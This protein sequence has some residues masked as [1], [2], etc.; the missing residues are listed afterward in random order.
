MARHGFEENHL[1]VHVFA[2]TA[3]FGH[4]SFAR[5]HAGGFGELFNRTLFARLRSGF[6][7]R[8]VATIHSGFPNIFEFWT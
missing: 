2:A 1:H 8:K 3:N 7:L 5:V 4:R 6:R